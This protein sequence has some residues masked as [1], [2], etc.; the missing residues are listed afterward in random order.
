LREIAD[1]VDGLGISS[2]EA[3]VFDINGHTV[4]QYQHHNG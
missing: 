3:N 4:G 2:R 1:N